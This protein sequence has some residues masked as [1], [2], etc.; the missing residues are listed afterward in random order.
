[1]ILTKRS[2]QFVAVVFLSAGASG[3]VSP[4]GYFADRW[5]DSKDIFTVAG[6]VG[7]GAKARV[8][9][10]Q[11]GAL[12]NYDRW[13]LRGGELSGLHGLSCSEMVSPLPIPIFERGKCTMLL[14]GLDWF[15]GSTGR[16]EARRKSYMAFS[17]YVPVVAIGNRAHYYT[18]MEV[19]AGLGGTLRLG[20]NPGELLDFILDWTTLD[21]YG[22]DLEARWAR[23][24]PRARAALLT[25]MRSDP[26]LFEGADPE[27]FAGLEMQRVGPGRYSWG[28]F[29]VN[30]ACS[31]YTATVASEAAFWSYRGHFE[32]LPSGEWRAVNTDKKHATAGPK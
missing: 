32:T 7:A 3:C 12:V 24:A 17:A 10:L 16:T 11:V 20:F 5:D 13:G 30:V 2:V 25:L 21:I 27:R 18:Q 19:A 28:A 8:G 31:S 9:P 23:Q 4:R 22:D 14:A 15:H 1:M 26:R 29:A 6:G